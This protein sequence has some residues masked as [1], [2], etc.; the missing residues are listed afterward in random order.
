MY[1]HRNI[2]ITRASSRSSLHDADYHGRQL[3]IMNNSTASNNNVAFQR[4]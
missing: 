4:I 3:Q 2:D 1:I